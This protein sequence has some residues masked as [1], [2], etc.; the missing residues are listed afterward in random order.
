MGIFILAYEPLVT[1]GVPY[2]AS[3]SFVKARIR[4]TQSRIQVLIA[5]GAQQKDVLHQMRQDAAC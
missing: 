5:T 1:A 3:Y 4:S 2:D